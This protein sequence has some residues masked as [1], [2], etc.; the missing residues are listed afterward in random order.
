MKTDTTTGHKPAS[1]ALR[2]VAAGLEPSDASDS[3]PGLAELLGGSPGDR[4]TG[5]GAMPC[6]IS[7]D[8]ATLPVHDGVTPVGSRPGKPTHHQQP[9]DGPGDDVSILIHESKALTTSESHAESIYDS[10]FDTV[11]ER[12]ERTPGRTSL[13]KLKRCPGDVEFQHNYHL[14]SQLGR[15]F[16]SQRW[17]KRRRPSVSRL[18]D[19]DGREVAILPARITGPCLS[20]KTQISR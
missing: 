3:Q 17:Q 7:L 19:L 9:Q 15:R 8:M 5:G 14:M 20:V 6:E 18:F 13:A 1:K 16:R 10:T 12:I 4:G 11:T 2:A